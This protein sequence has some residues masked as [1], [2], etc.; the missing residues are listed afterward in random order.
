[1]ANGNGKVTPTLDQMVAYR[2]KLQARITE[3]EESKIGPLKN[4]KS[5]IDALILEY[6]DKE[7]L[8]SAKTEHGTVYTYTK[9]TASVADGEAFMSYVM[10]HG[11]FE[12]IERRANVTAV[13]DF[14][15]EHG[16]LP[17]GVA[18]NQRQTV[19]VRKS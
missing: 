12:L 5:E 16:T 9:R 17:P 14:A 1:M 18:L 11:A 2:Q 10:A 7:K 8:E 3:I 13:I 19:G 15:E 6:L 4:A